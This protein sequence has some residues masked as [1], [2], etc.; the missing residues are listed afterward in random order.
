[1]GGLFLAAW[2]LVLKRA[3]SDRLIVGAAFITV[4]LAAALL[5]AGPIYSEAVALSGLERTLEDAPARDSGLEVSGRIPLED[6]SSTDDRVA[7]GIHRVLGDGVAVYRSGTSDSYA[8]PEGE[9]R[10]AD[11][12]AVF[13]FYDGLEEHASLV[14]G[15]WPSSVGSGA[16]EAALPAPAADALGLAPGDE[17]T[18]SAIGDP[19]KKVDARIS[20]TYQVDDARDAFWWGHRL[21]THGERTIDFTTYGPFVVTEDAFPSVA[22]SEANLAWRA[23][24]SPSNFTV[25]ALPGLREDVFALQRQLNE[26]A[27][28]EVTVDTGLV[29]VLDRTDHLLTVTRS[30][31]LI[32]SVQVARASRRWPS[33]RAPCSQCPPR[34]W[35][36]GWRSS[37]CRP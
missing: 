1:M 34:S 30:G 36:P 18:L 13:G 37:A 22:G 29:A 14:T 10:S 8:V 3:A 35:R 33:W 11:A 7:S 21:E 31:V 28:R 24:A 6:A 15:D 17:L 19:A 2:R 23:A 25:A 12:L 4:L 32:P 9:G 26:G 27:A 20:G 5:A 16:V